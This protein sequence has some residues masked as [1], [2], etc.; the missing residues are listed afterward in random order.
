[1]VR[2]WAEVAGSQAVGALREKL[3]GYLRQ[4]SLS[5]SADDEGDFMISHGST[6][7][8]VRAVDWTDG[9][10]LVRVWS[11]TNVGMHVNGELTRFLLTT[12]AKLPF[13]GFRLDEAVPAVM[14]VHCLLGEYLNRQELLTTV[15]AVT[16]TAEQFAGEIKER[17]GGRLFTES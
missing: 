13:G 9:R 6:I 17:F 10:T 11:I 1:M 4:A 2:R 5:I 16:A 7:T 15:G 3:D 12:N 14:L 8:W